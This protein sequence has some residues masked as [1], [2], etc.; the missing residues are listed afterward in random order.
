MEE[1]VIFLPLELILG[2]ALDG[3]GGSVKGSGEGASISLMTCGDACSCGS[4]G[5]S[6]LVV[7]DVLL[8]TVYGISVL[9]D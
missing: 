6:E 5:G 7:N 4:C 9:S 1:T 3:S 2:G 8:C